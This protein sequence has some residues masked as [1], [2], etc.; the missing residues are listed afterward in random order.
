VLF[1]ALVLLI[2][3]QLK[4]LSLLLLSR[5]EF[6]LAFLVFP[7]DSGILGTGARALGGRKV[8]RMDCGWT[9]YPGRHRAIRNGRAC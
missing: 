4:I 5:K 2:L 3:F 8:T 6:G 9:L 7:V 1:Q